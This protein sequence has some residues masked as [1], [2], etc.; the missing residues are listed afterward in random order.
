MATYPF[1]EPLHVYSIPPAV[2]DG[3]SVRTSPTSP[4]APEPYSVKT[5][6]SDQVAVAD[7]GNINS[8]G[9]T[10]CLGAGFKDVSEQRAHFRSDWHRYNVKLRLRDAKSQPVS[11][12]DFAALMDGA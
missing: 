10:L 8:T 2:L 5:A 7:V 4:Q 3:L 11:E 12:A 1:T 6:E 9:C